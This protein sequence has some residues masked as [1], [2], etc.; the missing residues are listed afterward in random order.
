MVVNIYSTMQ[1]HS[2]LLQSE[3][4]NLAKGLRFNDVS[5][6]EVGKATGK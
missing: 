2:N 1:I 6:S 5:E 3:I 4:V